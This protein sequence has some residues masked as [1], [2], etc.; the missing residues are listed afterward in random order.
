MSNFAWSLSSRV[1]LVTVA[2]AFVLKGYEILLVGGCLVAVLIEIVARTKHIKH[3]QTRLA[4]VA[5]SFLELALVLLIAAIFF[6]SNWAF[7]CVLTTWIGAC[8]VLPKWQNS[9]AQ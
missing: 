1:L 3:R 9:Q 2:T 5:T 7:W 8:W 4:L 6:Q